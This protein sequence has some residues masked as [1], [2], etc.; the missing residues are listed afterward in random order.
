[1]AQGRTRAAMVQARRMKTGPN[2]AKKR[3]KERE[4]LRSAY[5][6]GHAE[7]PLQKGFRSQVRPGEIFARWRNPT[8]YAHWMKLKRRGKVTGFD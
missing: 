1:M 7:T 8:E 4:T 2:R 6:A 3:K 5:R